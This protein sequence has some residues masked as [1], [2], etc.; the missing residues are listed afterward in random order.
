MRRI[1]PFATRPYPS[2]AQRNISPAVADVEQAQVDRWVN[3][4]MLGVLLAFIMVAAANSLVMATG[5]RTRELA[6]P[7]LVG[8][9]PAGD[10]DDPPARHALRENPV[11]LLGA[12]VEPRNSMLVSPA[13]S[14][15]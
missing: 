8:A 2:G 12:Q 10:P 1:L 14:Q 13:A 11:E 4:L 3:Y 15:A 9:F 5:E 7:R 6:M